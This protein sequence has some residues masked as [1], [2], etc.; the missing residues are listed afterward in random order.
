MI[1]LVTG[2]A[3]GIGEAVAKRLAD[4]GAEVIVADLT[5]DTHGVTVDL[6]NRDACLDLVKT[7]TSE[8]G[9]IDILVNNAG[10]Q[11]VSPLEEFDP[12]TWDRMLA[13]ML[14]AP[15]LLSSAVIGAMKEK[16]WGR[17]INMGSIHSLVASP[18]KAGYVAAKHGLVGLTKTTALEGGLHGVTANAL[19]PA[20]VR[21]PLVEEQIATQAETHGLEPEQVVADIMLAPTAG[22]R[23]IEPQEIAAVVSFLC[24]DDGAS[25]NGATWTVDMGWTA[26]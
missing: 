11:H 5:P 18:F 19:C 10:L 8:R 24:S 22:D 21:T 26:R 4:D 6:A 7:V 25:V 2:G 17:I 20:Y 16:G 3:S 9:P 12:E 14:T 15:F 13:V 1:A 23:L